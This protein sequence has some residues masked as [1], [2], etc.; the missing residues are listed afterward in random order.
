VIRQMKERLMKIGTGREIWVDEGAQEH[1]EH[2]IFR[3]LVQTHM[4]GQ[5]HHFIIITEA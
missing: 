5:F 2:Y 1:Q 3:T 4:N